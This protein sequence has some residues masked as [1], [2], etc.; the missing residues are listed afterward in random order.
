MN[1]STSRRSRRRP[2]DRR[3]A[4]CWGR[5]TLRGFPLPL[6][7]PEAAAGSGTTR[8]EGEGAE[9][10]CHFQLS[11]G[12]AQLRAGQNALIFSMAGRIDAAAVGQLQQNERFCSQPHLKAKPDTAL[13]DETV[14]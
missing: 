10:L 13:R 5:Q 3:W 4:A 1:R 11:S 2:R 6:S 12:S 14:V 7:V 8:S 9:G